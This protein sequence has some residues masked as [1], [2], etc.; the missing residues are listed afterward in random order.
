MDDYHTIW[1]FL[2]YLI[3]HVIF[4]VSLEEVSFTRFKADWSDFSVFLK[5]VKD[6]KVIS[7][8][9]VETLLKPVTRQVVAAFLILLLKLIAS[10]PK[11]LGFKSNPPL[12][13]SFEVMFPL[14]TISIYAHS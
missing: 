6:L 5:L 13:S 12:F 14:S 3:Q 4:S 11:P 7:E 8:S 9:K 10:L 1:V 2:T